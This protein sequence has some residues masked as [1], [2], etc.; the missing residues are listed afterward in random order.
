MD[1]AITEIPMIN[2]PSFFEKTLALKLMNF[3]Q[4]F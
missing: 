3:L 1:E 4:R 2:A